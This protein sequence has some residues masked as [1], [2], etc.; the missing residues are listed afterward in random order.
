MG[1]SAKVFSKQ[2]KQGDE[3][4][5]TGRQRDSPMARIQILDMCAM[6]QRTN[7]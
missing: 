5:R 1:P 7:V 4:K 3:G 2:S 6:M